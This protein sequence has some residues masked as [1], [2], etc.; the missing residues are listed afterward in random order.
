MD[1]GRTFINVGLEKREADLILAEARSL[2]LTRSRWVAAL[3]RR[4]VLRRPQ[5]SRDGELAIQE[6]HSELR[7]VRTELNALMREGGVD[8]ALGQRVNQVGDAIARAMHSLRAAF[9]GNLDYWDVS[10]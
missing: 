1:K 3:V 4:H 5:F 9:H 2:G 6:L 7:R 10:S 8:D